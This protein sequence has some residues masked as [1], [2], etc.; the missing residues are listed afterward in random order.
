MYRIRLLGAHW[1]LMFA[2]TTLAH[3][4]KTKRG[5]FILWMYVASCITNSPVFWEEVARLAKCL[6]LSPAKLEQ[7][8][9]GIAR[10]K[11]HELQKQ[12]DEAAFQKER[13]ES[14]ILLQ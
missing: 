8:A 12:E 2:Y 5:I 10:E 1:C 13:C 6:P 4:K 9:S 3:T 14:C 7:F 11:M